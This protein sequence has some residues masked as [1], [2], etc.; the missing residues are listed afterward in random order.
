M[1]PTTSY[2]NDTAKELSQYVARRCRGRIVAKTSLAAHRREA[3][4]RQHFSSCLELALG[5][6]D[7][8]VCLCVCVCVCV[9]AIG[10]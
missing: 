7:K 3:E 5:L 9:V 6:H 4:A 10:D 1:V 2:D 8:L